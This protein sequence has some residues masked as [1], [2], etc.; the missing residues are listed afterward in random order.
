MMGK[1]GMELQGPGLALPSV[2]PHHP[3]LLA[4][5]HLNTPSVPLF[6][7]PPNQNAHPLPSYSFKD[8]LECRLL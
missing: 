7:L 3:D 2:S 1:E 6:M 4:S 8:K 5:A